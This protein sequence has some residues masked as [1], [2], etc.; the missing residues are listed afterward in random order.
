MYFMVY[1]GSFIYIG[2]SPVVNV[3][4][5]SDSNLLTWSPPLFYSN[6]SSSHADFFY[7]ILLNGADMIN[8]TTNTSAYLNISNCAFFTI[9]I[10]VHTDQ[11]VSQENNQ[12]YF[13]SGSKYSFYKDILLYLFIDYTVDIINQTVTFVQGSDTVNIN[14]TNLVYKK[15]Q[16]PYY[17]LIGDIYRLCVQQYHLCH[18]QCY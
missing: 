9:S 15:V 16:L 18:W 2:V 14:L 8:D 13:D 7:Y 3:E 10:I 17:T 6:G 1:L 4:W 11:Y 12:T 5:H